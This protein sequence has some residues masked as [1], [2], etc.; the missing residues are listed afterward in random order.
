M[1]DDFGIHEPMPSGFLGQLKA[2][3]VWGRPGRVQEKS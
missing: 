3:F 2:P 1:P